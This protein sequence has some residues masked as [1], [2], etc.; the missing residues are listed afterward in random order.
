MALTA[1]QTY[2]IIEFFVGSFGLDS[3]LLASN[4]PLKEMSAR[5]VFCGGKDDRS[6]ELTTLPP[7]FADF[8]EI[9]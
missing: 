6:V 8:L 2:R 5:G 9:L 1:H 4:Q 3:V 7:S